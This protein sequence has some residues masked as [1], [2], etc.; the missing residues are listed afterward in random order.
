MAKHILIPLDGSEG[1]EDAFEFALEEFSDARITLVHV[2]DPKSSEKIQVTEG[3]IPFDDETR[4]EIV[5]ESTSFLDEYAKG[6]EEQGVEATKEYKV[7]DPSEE[8]VEYAEENEVDH[9]VMGSH[10]RSGVSR[11]LLG[12]VAEDV[13]R[14][15]P[16]PVTV[17]R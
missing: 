6:A 4:E 12:S 13:T 10:G 1:S 9:I 14:R 7:G 3:S 8:I 5:E 16:V 11:V 15:S 2:V 17:V